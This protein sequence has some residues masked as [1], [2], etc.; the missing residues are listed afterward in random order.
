MGRSQ[1]IGADVCVHSH[2]RTAIPDSTASMN[3][4]RHDQRPLYLLL[5]ER[6][7]CAPRLLFTI[8]YSHVLTLLQG[9]TFPNQKISGPRNYL[10]RK[11]GAPNILLVPFPIMRNKELD[12]WQ[13]HKRAD[14]G[15]VDSGLHWITVHTVRRPALRRRRQALRGICD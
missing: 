2:R 13:L 5:L 14:P 9:F 4:P 7:T 10:F 12:S 6:C 11:E 1:E 15:N 3:T 8:Q